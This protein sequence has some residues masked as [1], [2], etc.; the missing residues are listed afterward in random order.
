M[1]RRAALRY[2]A[3]RTRSLGLAAST[4]IPRELGSSLQIESSPDYSL[5][6]TVFFPCVG[7]VRMA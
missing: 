4:A 5:N 2:Q 6:F 1:R 7:A 3:R